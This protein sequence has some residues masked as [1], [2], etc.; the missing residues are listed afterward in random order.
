MTVSSARSLV[1]LRGIRKAYVTRGGV[2]TMALRGVDLDVDAGEFL[3][4]MG[5]SGSGKST[6]MNIVGLLDRQFEGKY[7]LGDDDVTGMST[8]R[9]TEVRSR[10]IGFVFQHFN[11]LPR[12]TV[13]DNIL[14]PAQYRRVHHAAD[15]AAELVEAVGLE[16]LVQRRSNQLSG[17]QMQRVAIARALMMDP[18]LVIADEPT[19]NLD[20]ETAA[21]ILALFARLH[22]EGRT[23]IVITHDD[24][25]AS[26]ADRTVVL[27]DG[28]VVGADEEAA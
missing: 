8:N 22:R 26:H 3:A 25:V 17:G 7:R 15:R 14:L 12:T 19:G 6:L 1:S 23:I 10:Q 28:Q 4:V 27:S 20:S 18:A 21:E 24:G 5:A 2:Q 16:A 9:A 11:L 13:L